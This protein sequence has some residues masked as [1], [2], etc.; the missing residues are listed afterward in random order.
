MNEVFNGIKT[1]LEFLNEYWTVIVIIIGLVLALVKRIKSY[2]SKSTDE[3]IEIA[4]EQINQ[5]IL[6]LV[7]DAEDYYC[8]T[9]KAGSIKRSQV[10]EKIY[11]QFP[12]LSQIASQEEIIEYIDDAIDTALETLRDIE[13]INA[14]DV[15]EDE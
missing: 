4:K 10:I 12:V 1:V 5:I 9:E 15:K 7:S 11:E 6:K 2:I 3:K 13:T 14:Q 8:S